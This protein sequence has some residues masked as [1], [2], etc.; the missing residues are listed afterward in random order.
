MA[1][2]VHSETFDPGAPQGRLESGLN[3]GPAGPVIVA[4]G[5]LVGLAVGPAEH[6]AVTMRKVC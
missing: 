4:T 6:L 2:I 5:A 1:A 3:R